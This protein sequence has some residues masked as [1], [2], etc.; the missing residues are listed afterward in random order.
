MMYFCSEVCSY[1]DSVDQANTDRNN[2]ENG[3]PSLSF[4]GS[5]KPPVAPASLYS[6]KSRNPKPCRLYTSSAFDGTEI[7]TVPALL[8][9]VRIKGKACYGLHDEIV[10]YLKVNNEYI[11]LAKSEAHAIKRNR[12]CLLTIGS[13]KLY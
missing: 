10:H 7:S 2:S 8:S 1:P 6:R 13:S 3:L 9:Q 11:C 12:A 4:R 5:A